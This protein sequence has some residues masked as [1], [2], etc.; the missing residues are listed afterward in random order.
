MIHMIAHI[1]SRCYQGLMKSSVSGGLAMILVG[2]LG[3][4]SLGGARPSAAAY[5]IAALLMVAGVL[6]LLKLSFAFWVAL[7]AAAV[8][9]GTGALAWLGHP[10]WA[11]PFPPW[12]SIVVGLLLAVRAIMTRVERRP[13]PRATDAAG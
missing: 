3:I 8:V 11:L 6:M 9:M 7:G 10:N 12:G 1:R 4:S 2:G 5:G 13:P